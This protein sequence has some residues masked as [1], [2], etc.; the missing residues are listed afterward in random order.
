MYLLAKVNGSELVRQ[1]Q[2]NA[3]AVATGF[4]DLWV[5]TLDGGVYTAMCKVG[6]LFALATLTF[7]IV[8]WTKKMMSAEEQRAYTDFIW[9]LIVI[10]LLS[11]NGKA[12]GNSILGVRNYIN[13]VNS[14]VLKYTAA[15]TNLREA[16][17]KSLITEAARNAIGLEI[18]KCKNSSLQPNEAIACLE[19]AKQRLKKDYPEQFN[20]NGG[21]FGWFIDAIDNIVE[22]PVEA[23]K[24]GKN[25]VEIVLSSTNALIGSSITNIISIILIGMNGAFQWT[26]ELTML[27]T[28]LIGPIAVGGS[29]LPYGA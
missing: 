25:P 2:E 18:Q 6:A 5:R 9:P 16:Y 11:N 22:A 24:D 27:V 21:V 14:T 17:Q 12:L 19:Q 26:I 4:N 15:E 8:E 29:L 28:A 13:N 20:K 10:L 1:A 3:E 7:F 23:I